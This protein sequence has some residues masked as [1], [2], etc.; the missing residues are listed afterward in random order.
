[1]ARERKNGKQENRKANNEHFFGIGERNA[2]QSKSKR[3]QPNN[4][5]KIILSYIHA[6]IHTHIFTVK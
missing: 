2:F 3:K 1:M 5:P 6:H 4:V